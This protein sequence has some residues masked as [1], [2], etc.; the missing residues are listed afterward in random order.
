MRIY[1]K[2]ELINF[3]ND[4][5]KCFNDGKIC[6]PVHLYSG[7]ED[8]LI[9]FSGKKFSDKNSGDFDDDIYDKNI[10]KVER[11]R[12]DNYITIEYKSFN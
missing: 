1:K 12:L 9:K 11:D 3:E 5:A 4:I 8:F 6:A 10:Y 7:N 2:K